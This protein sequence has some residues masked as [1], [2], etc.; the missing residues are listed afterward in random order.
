[1]YHIFYDYKEN[2]YL[3]DEIARVCDQFSFAPEGLLK[4]TLMELSD[5]SALPEQALYNS[6]LVRS[7]S[8][9]R[10]PLGAL[11]LPLN[12]A[13]PSPPPPSSAAGAHDR[14]GPGPFPHGLERGQDLPHRGDLCR[15]HQAGLLQEGQVHGP[16][17]NRAAA[18]TA[19]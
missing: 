6:S 15:S 13:A 7:V 17:A 10:C 5:I 12:S 8:G 4:V 9:G 16:G 14:R 19:P 18:S 1:M 11:I 3:D 2:K